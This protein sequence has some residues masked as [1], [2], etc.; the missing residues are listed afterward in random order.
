MFTHSSYSIHIIEASTKTLKRLQAVHSLF[1]VLVFLLFF[2]L[3]PI[4]R[5]LKIVYNHMSRMESI[6]YLDNSPM[7]VFYL[8]IFNRPHTWFFANK[9]DENLNV[10]EA[11]DSKIKS[12]K[13]PRI[14]SVY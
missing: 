11:I 10:R 6:I 1:H 7:N 3:S 2:F 8:Q 4:N 9:L 12:T 5:K 14:N 13:E